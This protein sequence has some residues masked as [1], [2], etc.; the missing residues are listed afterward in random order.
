MGERWRRGHESAREWLCVRWGA[1]CGASGVGQCAQG[2]ASCGVSARGQRQGRRCLAAVSSRLRMA[3]SGLLRAAAG[4]SRG[5]VVA[6]VHCCISHA[7]ARCEHQNGPC[8]TSL[9]T[10][11]TM[12]CSESCPL[13]QASCMQQAPW[14]RTQACL[15]GSRMPHDLQGAAEHTDF[16]RKVRHSCMLAIKLDELRARSR[17][18]SVGKLVSGTCVVAAA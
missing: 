12:V 17:P 5:G 14:L 2:G 11:V 4:C 18:V 7:P 13:T 15:P 6:P 3:S 1:S 9:T 8:T 10:L 16:D